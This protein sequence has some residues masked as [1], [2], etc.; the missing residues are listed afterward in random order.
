MTIARQIKHEP[1]QALWELKQLVESGLYA[2]EQAALRSA[3]RALFQVSPQAKTQMIA[4]AYQRGEIG[5]G[6]ASE[7]LGLS[8]EEMK[9]ILREAGIAIHLGPQ[10]PDELLDDIQNA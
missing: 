9:D 1:G 8:Q 3:L 5:L 4:S 2:D 6:K 10:T 7:L